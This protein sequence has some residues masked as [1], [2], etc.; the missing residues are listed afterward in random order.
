MIEFPP[1]V[2]P[3]EVPPVVTRS[4]GRP[5][6]DMGSS[7]L[8]EDEDAAAPPTFNLRTVAA[9]LGPSG[10]VAATLASLGCGEYEDRESQR[11]MAA[12]VAGLYNDGGV[13]L[14]EAGTGVGKSLAYLVPALRWAAATGERTVVSTNT[15]NLQEQL[16]GKDLP[17][18]SAALVDQP[19]RFALLKGWRNYLCLYRLDH[20]LAAGTTL[21]EPVQERELLAVADWAHA[22]SDGSLADPLA[23]VRPGVVWD[24]IAAEPDLCLR[25]QCPRFDECF[26]FRARR[27]AAEAEVVV[28]N[29]HLL[30]SDVAVRRVQQNWHE[31]AVIPPYTRLVVDEGH[32]LEDAAAAHLGGSVTRRGWQR[33]F[34]RLERR[35]SKGLVTQLAQVLGV[36][37]D[38]LA[39]A[40]IDLL[41]TTLAPAIAAARE[42]G[43]LV[44]DLL[45]AVMTDTGVTQLRLSDDF[46]EHPVW[47]GGL[48]TAM[49]DLLREVDAIDDALRLVQA[50]HGADMLRH[51]ALVRVLGELRGV[52]RRLS[53]AGGTLRQA[54]VPPPLAEPTVRWV[55][56]RRGVR[57][58]SSG[59]DAPAAPN[60]AVCAVPLDLAPVLREDLFMR[61]DTAVVTSATLTADGRFEFLASR[62]GLDTPE[63]TARTGV[64]ASPFDYP[65][66]S[67]L[68]VPT[69]LPAPNVDAAG[70]AAAVVEI[71][72][73]LA[74]I[75]GGGGFV[76][77]TS[78]RDVRAA[79]AVLRTD[80]EL[81]CELLVQGEL[82]RDALLRRFRASGH[83]LLLGTSSFWEGVD[84]PGS[85]LRAL[86][87]ARL[88]FRVPTEPVTAAQCEA[89]AARGGDPF[90]EYMLPHAALRLKQGF[91]RLI[92]STTD[93]GVVVLSDPRVLTKPYGRELLDGLPPARRVAAR[94]PELRH[95]IAAFY[96]GGRA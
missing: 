57:D 10:P 70:H 13:G 86:V 54:L 20:A 80:D 40:T 5:A 38:L 74:G 66:Q 88:P 58:R 51:E 1:D 94:W 49:E 73:D 24:E 45:A 82:P 4:A 63:L 2:R 18:L 96:D 26:L 48:T 11:E 31:A 23:P 7:E 92:R 29:H 60:V 30:M 55:E 85:A 3:D 78:H 37:D 16:V 95:T 27:V 67:L 33:L 47:A 25:Q 22:S 91:G 77:F 84:V 52:T 62:L 61:V 83:A 68:V 34:G 64:F 14:L 75:S 6:P 21:F 89:I 36:M 72:R 87:I 15:I 42:R 50:R 35:G 46:V 56:I 59:E 90:T 81:T 19:V 71:V 43:E 79:A 69:D 9:D 65:R 32:H 53:A 93:R 8:P 44:F 17:L 12:T 39:S 76:L 28:V 41:R